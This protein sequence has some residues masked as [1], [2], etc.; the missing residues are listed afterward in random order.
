MRLASGHRLLT[1]RV[2][3]VARTKAIIQYRGQTAARAL[4][5]APA[6]ACIAALLVALMLAWEA[7]P[8]SAQSCQI[9]LVVDPS[10]V[11]FPYAL[12]SPGGSP[13]FGE[14]LDV[15]YSSS[16]SGQQVVLQYQSGSDW[17]YLQNFTANSVGFTETSAG[18][19]TS[20]ARSGVNTLRALSGTCVSQTA[21]FSVSVDS[22]ALALDALAYGAL[23]LFGVAFYFVGKHVRY[24]LFVV[25]AAALYV[26][27]APYTGQ[28]YDVFF[29]ASSGIHILQNVNPFDP[30]HAALY[31]SA[32][33]WAYP[34]LY[35]LYSALSYIIY[36]AFTRAPLPSI[37]SLTWPGYLT[38]TYNVW[39]AFVPKALPLLVFILKVPMIASALATAVLLRRMTGKESVAATWLVNPLVILV[40]AVWGQLDPIS[41]FLALAS[42]YCYN[43]GK[44]YHAYFLASAGAAV[45]L[46]PALL[47]PLFFAMDL[48]REGRSAL[49]PLSAVLPAILASLGVY[50]VYGSL[51]QT[52]F[53]FVYAR[54]IPTYAG[55]FTVNGLTW[56]QILAIF[57]FPP[58]PLFL[59]LGIPL[60]IV[61]L[62]YI[63]RRGDRD[64][65][66]WLVVSLLIFYLTYNYVN[67]QYFYWILPFLIL[68]GRRAATWLFTALPMAYVA[69]SYNIFYFV[70]PSLL[71]HEFSLGPSIVEQLKLVL[72]Y[73]T[74][75]QYVLISAAI[76][77]AACLLLLRHELGRRPVRPEAASG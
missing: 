36:Q 53:V 62:A 39:E 59:I 37:S 77:T 35:A 75:V 24:G 54:G 30:G 55:E 26:A 47:I 40:A 21:R 29:L 2:A 16:L 18:L 71:L 13:Q 15:N 19:N 34:P 58:V 44:P 69:L 61:L 60:Y 64:V 27:I 67:P 63:Y 41:T 42:L 32:L 65:A 22:S 6:V 10:V 4:R 43:K 14:V 7:P 28:R 51:V 9:A 72:F 25:I 3:A 33:K 50:A 68:Q 38:S 70:S 56:Q 17:L 74:P 5:P 8:V 20:W 52:L 57:H 48:R 23:L 46:W 76:P 49:R 31:P 1:R 11:H 45:K 66:K 73:T 12:P